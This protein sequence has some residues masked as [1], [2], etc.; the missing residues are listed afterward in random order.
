[1][2]KLREMGYEAKETCESGLD[3]SIARCNRFRIVVKGTGCHGAL[4]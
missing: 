3:T 2:D 1:M 4:L